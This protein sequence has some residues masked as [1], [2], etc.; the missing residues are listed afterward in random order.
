MRLKNAY[1]KAKHG[2]ELY[3]PRILHGHIVGMKKGGENPP[4]IADYLNKKPVNVSMKEF[5]NKAKITPQTQK[6]SSNFSDVLDVAFDAG[7]QIPGPIGMGFS[8]AGFLNDTYQGDWAG[9]GLNTAN[10]LTAGASKGLMSTARRL[11]SAGARNLARGT[12]SLSRG[13]NRV[14]N[15]VN[16]VT[17]PVDAGKTLL[18][19]INTTSQE[20]QYQDNTKTT[21]LLKKPGMQMG[22]L[23]NAYNKI[24]K[25][26]GKTK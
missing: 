7:S 26:Y 15:R 21:P 10:I 4:R 13:M 9:V 23:Q 14:S 22:G 11:N 17:K 25:S 3:D 1:K 18:S 20:K 2:A 16:A 6:P 19:G 8:V 5:L 12:A 24:K